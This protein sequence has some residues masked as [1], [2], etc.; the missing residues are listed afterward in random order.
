MRRWSA[1][2]SGVVLSLGAAVAWCSSGVGTGPRTSLLPGGAGIEFGRDVRPILAERCFACHGRDAGARKAGLRL[3]TREGATSDRDGRGAAIVAGDPDSG[4]LIRRVSSLDL[5][6][7]MPPEGAG[8]TDAEIAVLRSWIAQGAAWERHWSL[9]PPRRVEPP[10]VREESWPSGSLDRFVLSSLER[11]G[12]E[13]APEADRFALARRVAL[14]LTGL[15]PR[16]EEVAAFA[17]DQSPDAYERYVDRLLASPHFGER[18]ASVWL[19]LARYAD[20]KGYEADRERTMWPY[21]DWVIDAFNS[22]M[23]FDRFTVEQLAGDLLRAPTHD[24][25]VATAFHRNTMTNDEGGTDD[26]EFRVAAVID[27]VNTTMQAWMGLTAGCAQCHDHKYDPISQREYYRLFAFFNNTQDA[28]R[29]DESPTIPAGDPRLVETVERLTDR[30]IALTKA[31][32]QTV[33]AWDYAEP[34]QQ[35]T[36]VVRASEPRD[37]YWIDDEE[38]AGSVPYVDGATAPW[39]WEKG[40][41]PISGE[42]AMVRRAR[43]FSQHYLTDAPIGMVLA[44]GDVLVA[45]VHIDPTAPT[46]EIMLQFHASGSWEH[47]AFWGQDLINFG[48]TGTTS[49]ARRGDLPEAGRW[50]RLEIPPEA[51]GLKAG[52]EIDGWA[53]SQQGGTVWWDAA[54]VRTRGSPRERWRDS[55]IAWIEEVRAR[56]GRGLGGEVSALVKRDVSGWTDSERRTVR[57][58]YLRSFNRAARARIRPLEE[59]LESTRMT[60]FSYESRLAQLPIMREQMDESR[61]THV[62]VGGSFLSPGERVE[63]GTPAAFPAFPAGARRD[64]LGLARWLVSPENPLTARVAVNRIWAR[65]FGRGLVLTEEDFGTQGTFPSHPELLDWLA[66]EFMESGWRIKPL[67][68]EMV[69]SRTY[70]QSCEVSSLALELDPTNRLL[71]RSARTPLPAEMVR[72]QALKVSGLLS[73]KLGGPS[74]FPPQPEGVWQVVYNGAQWRTSEGDDRYRRALYTFWRRTSPYPSMMTFDAVSREVCVARRVPSSSPLQAF[75]TLNDPAFVEMAQG[76]ARR[77]VAEGGETIET[78]ARFAMEVALCRPITGRE[79]DRLVALYGAQA[80]WYG[81]HA[82]EA[83]RMATDPIGAIPDGGDAAELAAWT[84]VANVVLNLDEFL[85]RP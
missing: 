19:D 71:S 2:I 26:E 24:Q 48:S 45:H 39:T 37:V 79:I 14:D 50:M 67:I 46:R 13:P 43:E 75:V 23:P 33:M 72:D 78:R 18:W 6:E 28:D 51:V 31:I 61:E 58:T 65:L 34:E 49:R 64:R 30:R 38:P 57:S 42:R 32:D 35:T 11:A 56:G 40:P 85:S 25:L 36:P 7:R 52:D 62:L 22:D 77:I 10:S 5:A 17:R 12:L 80:A 15:P 59:E 84:V 63:R 70:R 55:E 3:D 47:R 41:G 81:A 82:E 44:E 68:R 60:L 27:R 83:E 74:V 4:L 1:A 16:P 66:V 8:L 69:L 73:E 9:T 54:G 20:T 21:R 29:A 76:F 53:F